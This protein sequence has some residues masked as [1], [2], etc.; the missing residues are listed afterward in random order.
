MTTADGEHVTHTTMHNLHMEN[1]YPGALGKTR[2][3][4]EKPNLGL[5]QN[6]LRGVKILV[7]LHPMKEQILTKGACSGSSTTQYKTVYCR[8]LRQGAPSLVRRC[9]MIR[10]RGVSMAYL[11]PS[12]VPLRS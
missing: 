8:D 4:I 6:Y 1:S 12:L 7:Q 5:Q 3:N 2:Y 10:F 11:I 9:A